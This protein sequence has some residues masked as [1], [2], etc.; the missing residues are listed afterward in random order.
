MKAVPLSVFIKNTGGIANDSELLARDITNKSLPGLVRQ[1]IR[2]NVLGERGT[3]SIDA[4][5]QRVFDAGYFPMKDN[6][7]AISDSELYD[8]IAR[9][10]QGDERVWTMNVR[11]AL[12]PFINEREVL[13]SWASEGFDATMTAEQIANR[14]RS[15]CHGPSNSPQRTPFVRIS[16]AS[17][18]LVLRL[19]TQWSRLMCDGSWKALASTTA[20]SISIDVADPRI[21]L[22]RPA[23]FT[24]D[25]CRTRRRLRR[26]SLAT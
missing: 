13:D 17:L 6:Y 21:S 14:P 11:A 25:I 20:P 22:P 12:D 16:S 15:S 5:K 7:N 19:L 18:R 23:S 2:Q 24:T 3:A 26:P 8:A 9:D 10:L 1:N 4:V